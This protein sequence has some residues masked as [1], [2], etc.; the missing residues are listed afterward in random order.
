MPKKP[1]KRSTRVNTGRK[2]SRTP[3]E[4]LVRKNGEQLRLLRAKDREMQE[5]DQL[6]DRMSLILRQTADALHGG[7]LADGYWSWHDLPELVDDLQTELIMVRS[8]MAAMRQRCDEE[9][10]QLITPF[11]APFAQM[12]KTRTYSTMHSWVQDAL[13]PYTQWDRL[14]DQIS[15]WWRKPYGWLLRAWRFM[16]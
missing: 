8:E 11:E 14:L 15:W 1:N 10:I 2:R 13:K 4:V 12:P 6:R 5:S 16:G 7:P 3:R 9:H